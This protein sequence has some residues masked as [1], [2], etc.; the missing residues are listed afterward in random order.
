[1]KLSFAFSEVSFVLSAVLVACVGCSAEDD[2]NTDGSSDPTLVES[3]DLLRRRPQ[4]PRAAT[5]TP[6]APAPATGN[7][8]D[9]I[10][11]TAQTADGRAV[12]QGSLENGQCPTVVALLGFWS[13]LTVN[14]QCTFQSGGVTHRCT[15]LRVDGE[16][17]YP[18]WSC[19]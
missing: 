13:C 15:C 7:S 8:P 5:P 11:A 4:R 12:P 14:D 9:A 6:P 18:A 17:Q 1:M 16:G 3:S 2:S 10:I 19:N